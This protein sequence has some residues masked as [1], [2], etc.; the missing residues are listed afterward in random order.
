LINKHVTNEDDKPFC[1]ETKYG[2]G[3]EPGGITPASMQSDMKDRRM[4]R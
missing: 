3:A 1:T 4:Y 2:Y